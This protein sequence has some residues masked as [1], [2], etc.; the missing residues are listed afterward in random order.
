MKKF[1]KIFTPDS[2]LLFLPVQNSKG[3]ERRLREGEFFTWIVFIVYQNKL[4]E[5]EQLVFTKRTGNREN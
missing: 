2:I 1:K 5:E 3:N 4:I